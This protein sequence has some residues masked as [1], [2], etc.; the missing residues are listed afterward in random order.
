MDV[1]TIGLHHSTGVQIGTKVI[2]LCCTS[3]S[4]DSLIIFFQ[5]IGVGIEV[6]QATGLALGLMWIC[7]G[8]EFVAGN[9]DAWL[10]AVLLNLSGK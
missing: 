7:P 6:C 3:W 4:N 5:C 8:R 1:T 2:M 10:N 9:G